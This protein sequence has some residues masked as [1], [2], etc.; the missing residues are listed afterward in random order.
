M[1]THRSSLAA[2]LL[3]LAAVAG[4][5]SYGQSASIWDGTWTGMQGRV[6]PGPIAISIAHGQ[7]VSYTI[8]GAPFRIEYSNVTPTS[9]S[10]GDAD[11]YFVK[12]EKT[13]DTTASGKIRGRLGE[14]HFRITRQ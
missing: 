8:R 13:G 7:V 2:A 14:G 3:S 9:V 6:D 10:F 1:L 12:L 4:A 11:H 5:P